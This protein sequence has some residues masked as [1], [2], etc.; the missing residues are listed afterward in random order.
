MMLVTER[1]EQ[2]YYYYLN[3]LKGIA[4]L[5]IMMGHYLGLYKYAQSFT[6][7]IRII[8]IINNSLLSFL[9]DEGYWLY[10]FFVVSG[11]LVSKSKITSIGDLIS[12]SIGRFLRLALPILFSYLVIYVIYLTLGFHAVETNTLFQCAWY[13]GY[14][15]GEYTI[16]D[17][18]L[19]PIYVIL[20][21]SSLLNGPYWCLRM[22][23]ISSLFILKFIFNKINSKS[24]SLVFSILMIITLSSYVISPIITACLVGM[25]VS[26]YE[27]S[28]IISKPVMLFWLL[29]VIMLNYVFPR[30][31]KA[32]LF[33]AALIV[34]VPRI[35][36][37]AMVLSSKP[38]QFLGKLSWGIYSFHWPIICSFGALFIIGLSQ[39]IG[40]IY[41][42]IV[43]FGFV[44]IL[45]FLFATCFY[46]T[47]E[48]FS[49]F[50][51]RKVTRRLLQLMNGISRTNS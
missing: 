45:T 25:L 43:S 5:L 4:C 19:A 23:F 26:Y 16:Y 39:N 11:Y 18:L 48:R 22:M 9:I 35:N 3:G 24:E 12:K 6:P 41:S 27:S 51:T 1:E 21:G 37:V 8:D 42:Y 31:L 30:E 36:I 33:F 14:Y 7:S 44:I 29:W 32:T 49:S 40:L 2:T 17:V 50:F 38:F 47:L 46:F 20:Y 34:F 28:E 10:M 13:Q 15:T